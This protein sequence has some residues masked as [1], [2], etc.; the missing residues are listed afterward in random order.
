[1]HGDRG[2]GEIFR[3]AQTSSSNAGAEPWG[4][5]RAGSA[6]R[7]GAG[8]RPGAGYRDGNGTKTGYRAGLSTGQGPGTGQG[9]GTGLGTGQGPGRPGARPGEA[10]SGPRRSQPRR[11]ARSPP[12]RERVRTYSGENSREKRR[13]RRREGTAPASHGRRKDGMEGSGEG[14]RR[15]HG[16]NVSAP[17]SCRQANYQLA[18]PSVCACVCVCVCAC[19]S[20]GSHNSDCRS[21]C[22]MIVHSKGSLCNP[23]K[24]QFLQYQPVVTVFTHTHLHGANG[25]IAYQ[26]LK[27]FAPVPLPPIQK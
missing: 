21:P 11:A 6:Y 13:K 4:G 9:L 27:H 10:P 18:K 23:L 15:P 14:I 2:G 22:S 20:G 25:I 19:V 7:A 3:R 8:Y 17:K 1:M 5:G 26:P 16:R 24:P 12:L